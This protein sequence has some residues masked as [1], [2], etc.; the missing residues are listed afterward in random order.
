M[1]QGSHRMETLSWTGTENVMKVVV[2]QSG[3]LIRFRKWVEPTGESLQFKSS[4]CSVNTYAQLT[5]LQN[6]LVLIQL[7]S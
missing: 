7:P 2:T 3:K 6:A 1:Q 4:H 5:K